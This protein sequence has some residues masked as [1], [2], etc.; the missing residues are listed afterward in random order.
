MQTPSHGD[1]LAERKRDRVRDAMRNADVAGLVLCEN[2]RTRYLTGY[3]RYHSATQLAPAHAV[4]MTLNDGPILMVPRHILPAAEDCAHC[5][6]PHGASTDDLLETSQPAVCISCHTL[7]TSGAVH[8]P[9]AFT[10]RCTDCHNAVHGS[11]T[12]PHLRR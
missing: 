6:V 11:Y 12:D 2:G 8:D 9:W 5:H 3:Q 10:T 4:V 7:S 1:G